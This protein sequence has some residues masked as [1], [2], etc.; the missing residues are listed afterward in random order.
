MYV[1]IYFERLNV[2][3]AEMLIISSTIELYLPKLE[4]ISDIFILIYGNLK[5]LSKNKV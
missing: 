5:V 4:R 3:F 2:A 1:E